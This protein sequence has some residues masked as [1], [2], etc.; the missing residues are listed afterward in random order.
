MQS[1]TTLFKALKDLGYDNR[2]KDS[3]W[4]PESG[5]FKVVVGAILTQN[6]TWSNVE[7]TLKI[8][9]DN[10]LIS[11][12]KL[13]N[14]DLATLEKLI[15]ASG[16][17]RAKAKNIKN[18]S[19]NILQDFGS[20]N[21][22]KTDVTR[23]WLLNQKGI[24]NESADAILNYACYK[25][26]FVVDSYT[27]RVLNSFGYEFSNYLELQ[28]WIVDDFYIGYRDVFANINRAQAYARAHGMIVE[29]CK[30]NKKGKNININ[31]IKNYLKKLV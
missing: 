28:E 22:F 16:F 13:S 29:Y 27:A 31:E 2:S 18:L 26:A 5:S 11:L 12:E 21:N 24:G 19:L 9:E 4:W 23:E 6:T 3:W 1:A 14:I 10:S 15:K 17:Y 7:K 30:V 20:F 25:E 8:L